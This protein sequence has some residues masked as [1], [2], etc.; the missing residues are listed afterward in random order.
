MDKEKNRDALDEREMLYYHFDGKEWRQ[1]REEKLDAS[2][3]VYS[4]TIQRLE[5]IREQIRKG[6]L[7]PLAYY[8]H[9]R[10]SGSTAILSG[11]SASIGLLSSYTGIAKRHIK[12]HLEPEYFNQLD[13]KTLEKY[14]EIFEISAEELK[15]I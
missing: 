4:D 11:Q 7:S 12:K 3:F 14:A 9:K 10:F 1:K 13:E 6:E 15:S 2:G 5:E 8:I